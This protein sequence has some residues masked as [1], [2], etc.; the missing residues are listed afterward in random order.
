M[1]VLESISVLN[2]LKNELQVSLQ[3]ILHIIFTGV[4][5]T[6]K[7]IGFRTLK[8]KKKK[9][10]MLSNCRW[11]WSSLKSLLETVSLLLLVI[12]ICDP[13]LLEVNKMVKK[14]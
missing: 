14:K 7:L 12:V 11:H 9:D 10:C 13:H 2:Q 6:K 1:S 3:F 4:L 5:K 8:K